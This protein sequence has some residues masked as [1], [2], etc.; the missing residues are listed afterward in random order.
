[1]I[2]RYYGDLGK[3]IKKGYVLIIFG[4]RQVGKTTLLENFLNQTKLK[5]KLDSGDNI[6]VRNLLE[7][8]D[9]D[10]I[11]GYAQNYDLIAIDE[12][13][14]IPNI[15]IALKILVDQI[16]NLSII[17]T[18]SSSFDLSQ[19]V[20]EPL[21]GRKVTLILY[22]VAQMELLKQYNKYELREKL[23]DFMIF[24]SY[25]DVLLSSNRED[26]IR[27]LTELVDSYLLKDVLSLEKIKKS[28]ILFN[29]VKL[30]AFQIGQL[31]SHNELATQ[32]G[33]D[34]KTVSRYLDLL[35]KSFVIKKL[36]GFSS[37]LR[38]EITKKHKYYFYDL[39][40][41]NAVVA[42]FNPLEL[43][44]DVGQ[45]WENFIFIERLKK[46]SYQGFYGNRYFWRTYQGQEID[47]IEE[48]ENKLTAFETKW[49]PT[50]KVTL[51]SEWKENYPDVSFNVI[52]PENYLDY[53]I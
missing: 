47:F 13:Q 25:P 21:T 52:T 15:G 3:Y 40:I 1:M 17:A 6:R 42:Q 43:R 44:N 30:L 24:G 45:L 51:P 18:G 34:V 35:E 49:S 50:K 14:Q 2:E 5:Y 53:V 29:L 8:Q 48:I 46:C 31:V 22:P 11:L 33:I 27:V 36:G 9:F 38:N 32:L 12:A 37:N 41:R 10:K 19:Q 20:G 16:K 26:K 4:P 28:E 23:E 7:S 39:G